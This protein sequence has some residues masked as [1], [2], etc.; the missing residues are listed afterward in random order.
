VDR[1]SWAG[2]PGVRRILAVGVVV[3]AGLGVTVGAA[4]SAAGPAA[5]SAAGPAPLARASAGA[6]WLTFGDSPQ[7]DGENTAE[8]LISAANV[9][10]LHQI[11]VYNFGRAVDNSPVEAAGVAVGAGTQNLVLAG[12]ENGM[13]AALNAQT[14]ATVWAR[15]LGTA[16]TACTQE[17]GGIY[18]ITGT[19]VVDRATN[20]VF[21]ADGT[22]AVYALDL[23]TGRTVKG[24]PRTLPIRPSREHVWGALALVSGHLYVP[25]G[26]LCDLNPYHGRLVEIDAATGTITADF[27]VNGSNGPHGGAIWGWGGAAV[28]P[29]TGD[30]YV[31]T[32]NATGTPENAGL[33]EAVIRLSSSLAVKAFSKPPLGTGSDLDFGSTP[34]LFHAPGCPA[35]LVAENKDG[36]LFLY[37]RS[38]IAAGPVQRIKLSGRALIGVAAWSNNLNLLFAANPVDSTSFSHGMVAFSDPSPACTLTAAW[39]ARVGAIGGVASPPIVANG[40]VYY[41]T[42]NVEYALNAATGALLWTSG[43]TITAPIHGAAIVVNGV[44]YV[45]SW[46]HKLHAF[47]P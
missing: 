37:D 47:A 31:A 11:W 13:F 8:T 33:S 9:G 43:S 19:A 35:Q 34:V 7:R 28:D 17:P 6:D 40:V 5:L 26:G 30:V 41:G 20:R 15:R 39:T 27:V 3:V 24:W 45:P 44:L 4:L 29:S 36:T 10:G 32:G 42:G 18:G 14:G 1:F 21:V 38:S 2:A 22:G 23:S 25:V 16:T 12:G 46:D